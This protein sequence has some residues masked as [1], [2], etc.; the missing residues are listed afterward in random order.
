MDSFSFEICVQLGDLLTSTELEQAQKNIADVKL[1]ITCWKKC[2]GQDNS[3]LCATR[4]LG[5]D[6]LSSEI[7]HFANW[8]FECIDECATDATGG[9]CFAVCFQS[10]TGHVNSGESTQMMMGCTGTCM[11]D[12]RCILGCLFEESEVRSLQRGNLV[13]TLIFCYESCKLNDMECVIMC[14]NEEH[15]GVLVGCA[16]ECN[17]A[18][19]A[20]V[21]HMMCV[22]KMAEVAVIG[23]E[24]Y[25]DLLDCAASDCKVNYK[26]TFC[27]NECSDG[28]LNC[29]G[30]CYVNEERL[31]SSQ[32]A[33]LT[34]FF[35]QNIDCSCLCKDDENTCPDYC[36]ES[37]FDKFSLPAEAELCKE[38]NFFSQ[39]C[40]SIALGI[41][42]DPL[43]LLPE[44]ISCMSSG[45]CEKT[46][47]D[48][49]LSCLYRRAKLSSIKRP[50]L[51]VEEKSEG[52]FV[53]QVESWKSIVEQY[54]EPQVYAA[55]HLQTMPQQMRC[56]LFSSCINSIGD[57]RCV[58]EQGLQYNEEINA[59]TTVKVAPS[60]LDILRDLSSSSILLK[61][62][63]GVISNSG[64]PFGY[65]N[66]DNEATE[67]LLSP[68]SA[69]A[70]KLHFEDFRY[71][72][73]SRKQSHGFK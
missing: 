13:S 43:E 49:I 25:S 38:E 48:C 73:Y 31:S 22:E 50:T 7:Y 6:R 35:V 16:D 67:W 36:D 3:A 62:E 11:S 70:F 72:Y 66:N 52:N 68:P 27:E 69:K 53:T 37:N 29:F 71:I 34:S 39:D 15:L 4:C 30:H 2:E 41:E 9:M 57:Y 26:N 21:C 18:Q 59:C 60:I 64:Y 1:S 46:D 24:F 63:K 54:E 47:D 10:R 58:C 33:E 5:K 55:S 32:N 14:T 19:Y 42:M 8:V 20:G 17:E 65:G 44:L 45:V 12:L 40:L 23:D 51:F 28:D 56:P 61:S